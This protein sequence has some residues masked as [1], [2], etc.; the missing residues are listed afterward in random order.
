MT[1]NTGVR[2]EQEQGVY[3]YPQ[4]Y[5]DYM[6]A[7]ARVGLQPLIDLS[8]SNPFYDHE[9]GDYTL[10]HSE[11]GKIGYSNYALELLR[12]YGDQINASRFG[13]R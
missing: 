12:H 3:D 11:A 8:W 1:S 6:A 13:T 10:P 2:F 9:D 5:L 7:A 4:K